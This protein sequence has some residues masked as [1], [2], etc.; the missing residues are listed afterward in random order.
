[1]ASFAR[2]RLTPNTTPKKAISMT[3]TMRPVRGRGAATG[4]LMNGSLMR[5]WHHEIV[6]GG[7]HFAEAD[8]GDADFQRNG[9]LTVLERRRT[10]QH[11]KLRGL[12][13]PEDDHG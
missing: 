12:V 5:S 8:I 10:D 11:A 4:L 3:S 7:S 6:G 13:A 2:V 9:F 1:M